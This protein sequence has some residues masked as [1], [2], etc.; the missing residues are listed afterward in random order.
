M[1]RYQRQ[2]AFWGIGPSGQ[3]RLSTARATI[4]G[5]GALGTAIANSLARAGFGFLRLVDS[6]RVE[7]SNLQ[8]QML[9]DEEDAAEGRY[10]VMAAR[11]HLER[12]NSRLRTEALVMRVDESNIDRLVDDVDVIL[13]GSDNFELRYAINDAAL[14]L[15]RPWIYGGVLADS[16]VSMNIIPGEGPCLRCLM[17]EIPVPGSFDTPERLGVLNQ[18]TAIIASVEAV[19]AIKVVLKSPDLRRSL[20]SISLWDASAHFVDIARNPA[21]PACGALPPRT[22]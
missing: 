10:K 14:R 22:Q 1:D 15:G 2:T 5:L 20:F 16:G 11:S 12:I 6:D 7:E 4:I 9:F 8:R 3:E 21:C 17:P 19:E 13:D 18:I